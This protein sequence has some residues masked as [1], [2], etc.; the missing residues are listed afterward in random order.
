MTPPTGPAARRPLPI[1]VPESAAEGRAPLLAALAARLCALHPGRR[2][3]VAVDGV[4]GSGKTT[5]ADALADTVAANPLRRPVVR[6]ALDDFHHPRAVR[7][8]LGSRSPEGFRRDSY[9]LEQFRAYVLDP[10]KPG[11]SGCCR[12]AGHDLASDAVLAP[13]PERAAASAVILVDGLFLHRAELAA[14]WDFSIFLDVPFAVTAARMAVR[15][16]SPSDPHHPDM[17]R[18]VG[19]QLLYF[20]DTD[21]AL[22]ASVVVENS[23]PEHPRVISAAD[24]NYRRGPAASG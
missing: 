7:H 4:D 1:P 18:Y 13:P 15:D 6:I 12:P 8:R 3:F 11:G 10:L 24:A 9:N 16:G 17:H 2:I 5:F 20:A 22:Q 23:H 21:P 19:G 14:D